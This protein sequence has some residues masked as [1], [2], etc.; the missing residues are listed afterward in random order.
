M[1]KETLKK[2]YYNRVYHFQNELFLNSLYLDAAIH[3]NIK[4]DIKDFQR[5]DIELNNAIYC[6][7]QKIYN[8]K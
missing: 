1:K 6:T 8:L 3:N 4:Q 5:I 7:M 2:L